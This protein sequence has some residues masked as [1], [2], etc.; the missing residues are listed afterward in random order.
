M[1]TRCSERSITKIPEL[2]LQTSYVSTAALR[3]YIL[4]PQKHLR[5]CF[6][7]SKENER[8]PGHLE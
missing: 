3:E 5:K 1:Y 7:E 4:N 6:D 8:A 2:V